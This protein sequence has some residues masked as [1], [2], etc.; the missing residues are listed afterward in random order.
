MRDPESTPATAI[1]R[2]EHE[3]ILAAIELLER[4][5][6]GAG[7]DELANGR[8]RDALAAFFAKCVVG[9]HHGK[10][11]AHLFPTLE[12]HGVAHEHG[13]LGVLAAEHAEGRALL[14]R[15]RAGGAG[16]GDAM[17]RYA[18]FLR[19]HIAKEETILFGLADLLLPAADQ[20]AI[21]AAFGAL[22]RSGVTD[23]SQ[24]LRP[25]LER[26]RAALARPGG[27]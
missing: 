21:A 25:Q 3:V 26:L 7:R 17:R 23:P 20:R 11:E 9:L 1:L 27:E 12:R 8:A 4:E 13:P 14:R 18:R 2:A 5:A 6:S 16:A 22:E 15:I 10:E 19:A 24:G